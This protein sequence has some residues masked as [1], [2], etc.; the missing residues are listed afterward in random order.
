[1]QVAQADVFEGGR[2]AV[3]GTKA[4]GDPQKVRSS[5]RTLQGGSFLLDTEM[6]DT[7]GHRVAQWFETVS[8]EPGR[9]VVR[10]YDLETDGLNEGKYVFKQGV[11]NPNWQGLRRW[12]DDAGSVSLVKPASSASEWRLTSDVSGR[13]TVGATLTIDASF[14]APA[15]ASGSYLLDTEIEDAQGNKVAQWFETKAMGGGQVHNMHRTWST[16]GL[17]PGRYALN[18][19]VFGENWAGVHSWRDNSAVFDLGNGTANTIPPAAPTTVAPKPTPTPTT[20]VPVTPPPAQPSSGNP[21]AG[22]TL[23]VDPQNPAIAQ[24]DAWQASRPA[25]AE[26]MRRMGK[27][28]AAAWVGGWDADITAAVRLRVDAAAAQGTLPVLI[29]Y[30]IPSRDCGL[31]SAGGAAGAAGYRTWIREVAAG[32]GNKRAVVILEPDALPG[33]TCLD[34]AGQQSRYALMNDAVDVLGANP[35]TTVYLDAGNYSWQ[36]AETMAAR[37]KTAGVDRARGFSMNVSGY[38]DTPQTRAYGDD[39]ARRLSNAHWVIDTSRN[40]NG[41]APGN[42]WCNPSGRALGASP[43][44]NTGSQYGDALLWLKRP[45][46]SDGNCNGGPSAGVWWPEYGLALAKAAWQ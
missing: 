43:T 34:E 25:D 42:E 33:I 45:G 36:S 12:I 10:D 3:V 28:A 21:F 29:A 41:A 24:A 20:A 44:T 1:M 17:A 19:G 40:G 39:L 8:M 46:E 27:T 26:L 18:Q 4:V 6:Y 22:R 5:F 31:Y 7:G 9:L 38:G 14:Q 35:G 13:R 16:N 23:W 30:N 11:F 15:G 2:V 32:I 37:L